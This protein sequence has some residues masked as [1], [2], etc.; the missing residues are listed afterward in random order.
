M[1]FKNFMKAEGLA[2]FTN[3]QLKNEVFRRQS[4]NTFPLH[5]FN[6]KIKPF[7]DSLCK[8]YD[9]PA[10][11]IG[12]TL[13]SAYS[14]AIG[15]AFKI[16]SGNED[17][18]Y[19]P[20][21]ACLCGI[22]SSG[23]TTAI[24]KIYQ[25]LFNIQSQ[26][27]YEWQEKT[28]GLSRE[29]VTFE[30]METVIYRDSHIAT[31]VRTILPDN[32]KGTCK[33]SDE[34]LEWINGMNQLTKKE[35]TDEQFWIS[36]WNC[37]PYS[38]IRSGKDKFIVERPYVNVIGKAQ[39]PILTKLFS[40]DR[41]TTG[42]IFR[43]LFALPEEDRISQR[44]SDFNMPKEWTE[45]H[46][47]SITR[48]FKD[49]PVFDSRDGRYC[50]ID[51]AAKKLLDQWR[52]VKTQLIN[53]VDDSSEKNIKAGVLGKVS[54]Y[55]FRFAAILHLA[56]KTFDQDYGGDFHL[57]FKQEELISFNTMSRALELADYFYVSANE[58]YDLV[59]RSLSAPPEVLATAFM[60]KRGKSNS[61][62][63]EMLYGS[64]TPKNK[65]KARRQ[66]ERWIKEYPRVFGAYSK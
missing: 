30:R 27:D 41:D 37:T 36:A 61:E 45:L 24:N 39:Y 1:S 23:G 4:K 35:G 26:F 8:G 15:T 43:M 64:N 14:T 49:L 6:P 19:L 50:T 55:A 63:G 21:W 5:V 38:G 48:L 59:Q 54:E 28:K 42:F 53:Q 17:F 29:K 12:T 58:V 7:L 51:P 25:P 33:H 20:V 34:L 3:D 9:L 32:P 2:T 47:R 11:Y 18:I 65:V 62:I 60:L 13:L 52:R 40:K 31:F 44:E 10:S 66:I 57:A 46:D 56:D 16:D 22:S